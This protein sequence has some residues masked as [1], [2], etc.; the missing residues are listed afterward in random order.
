MDLGVNLTTTCTIALLH[1]DEN[2]LPK[3][4]T[5]MIRK[6]NGKSWFLN[7]VD[8]IIKS[9]THDFRKTTLPHLIID[10]L[11]D[12]P[13]WHDPFLDVIIKLLRSAEAAVISET[14]DV[15]EVVLKEYPCF[16][17]C[18]AQQKFMHSLATIKNNTNRSRSVFS[19][20]FGPEHLE[21]T[22]DLMEQQHRAMNILNNLAIT[23]GEDILPIFKRA[24]DILSNKDYFFPQLT[25]FHLQSYLNDMDEEKHP[26]L[27][28]PT[29]NEFVHPCFIHLQN[30]LVEFF[31]SMNNSDPNGFLTKNE[32]V[33]TKRKEVLKSLE[34]VSNLKL[35]EDYEE[36]ISM[37]EFECNSVLTQY[38]ELCQGRRRR[39]ETK[40][41][42]A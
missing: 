2:Q 28:P 5:S 38:Q 29:I 23:Y 1:S 22:H 16:H 7:Y 41:S 20:W 15:L 42:R 19:V 6:N 27:E 21:A 34:R 32:D 26:F 9:E 33:Q 36:R 13:A 12:N 10:Y 37:L 30:A 18:C 39:F 3:F 17:I 24:K 11:T 4:D 8:T 14:F 25:D 35:G 40:Q 31:D